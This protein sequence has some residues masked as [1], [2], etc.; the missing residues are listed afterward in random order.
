M[1]LQPPKLHIKHRHSAN[2]PQIIIRVVGHVFYLIPKNA[3][4]AFGQPQVAEYIV[5]ELGANLFTGTFEQCKTFC[6]S[7]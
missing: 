1:S 6:E 3:Q 5:T 2:G 4:A 7:L